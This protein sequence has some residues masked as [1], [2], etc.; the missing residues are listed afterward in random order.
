M[1]NKWTI[2]AWKWTSMT[3]LCHYLETKDNDKLALKIG[4]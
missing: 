2:I 3:K 1:S 4:Q